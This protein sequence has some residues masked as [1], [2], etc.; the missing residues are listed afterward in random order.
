MEAIPERIRGSIEV[1]GEC[2]IWIGAR[3]GGG[4]GVVSVKGKPVRVHRYVYEKLK[5]PVRSGME[6]HH[7]KC[8]RKVCCNPAHMKEVTP[9]QH[10]YIH[11]QWDRDRGADGVRQWCPKRKHELAVVGVVVDGK[12]HR[13]CRAC[14]SEKWR[15]KN[16]RVRGKKSRRPAGVEVELIL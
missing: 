6:L 9:T 3:N 11:R 4:Y 8:E 2:W 13:K 16:A 5:G 1:V 10:A 14:L 12:G 15:R 7:D